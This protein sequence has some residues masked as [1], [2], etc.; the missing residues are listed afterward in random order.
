MEEGAAGGR[1]ES[2]CLLTTE[3]TGRV[4]GGFSA[5]IE[6]LVGGRGHG[7][8]AVRGATA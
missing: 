5:A 1:I 3:T 7:Q 8:V 4:G 6:H 2:E